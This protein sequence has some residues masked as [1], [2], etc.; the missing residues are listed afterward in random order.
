MNW[1][2]VTCSQIQHYLGS[3]KCTKDQGI[4]K[5][6]QRHLYL[7]VVTIIL[8]GTVLSTLMLSSYFSWEKNLTFCM[9]SVYIKV[10]NIGGKSWQQK[11][12]TYIF[13]NKLL[14]LE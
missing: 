4:D 3:F 11:V 8:S 10:E 2:F 6:L 12:K 9:Y 13:F 1:L 5:I 14:A 7:V